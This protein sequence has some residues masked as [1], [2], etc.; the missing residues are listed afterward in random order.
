ME[1]N[2]DQLY[3]NALAEHARFL[4]MDPEEDKDLMWCV[5]WLRAEACTH[6]C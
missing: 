1:T 2:E 6:A 5:R 3:R 4:G